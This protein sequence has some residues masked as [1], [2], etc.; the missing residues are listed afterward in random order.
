M[1]TVIV[2]VYI[3]EL[4][5]HFDL[6]MRSAGLNPAF[7]FLIIT[8]QAAPASAPS[9][10]RFWHR[11]LEE[12]K[13]FWSQSLGL[14]AALSDPYKLNDFK[15]LFWMLVDNLDDY[16]Y[17]GFCDLDT[18]LGDLSGS[19]SPRL[20]NYDA[21]LSEGHLRLFRNRP[22]MHRLWEKVASPMSGRN[23][24]ARPG[25]FGMDEHS[26]INKPLMEGNYGWF[27][28]PPLVAD[29]DPS[30]RRFRCLPFHENDRHQAFFWQD[31]KVFRES[32]RDGVY[33]LSE[34]AYIHFQK[35]KMHFNPQCLHADAVDIGPGGFSVRDDSKA[36]VADIDRRNPPTIFPNLSEARILAKELR[37]RL[38]GATV[39]FPS[40]DRPDRAGESA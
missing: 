38:T 16:D 21:I 5:G 22:E 23:I 10:V 11:E 29:I 3:G 7:E 33:Q 30:F 31:G 32:I 36:S 34:Y 24:L 6:W 37:R 1:K 14:N 27:S 35:R 25:F 28:D 12:L 2:S 15:P 39:P 9:N 13:D 19:I 20:G 26:G 8:D 18:L 40:L 17:W 4:P